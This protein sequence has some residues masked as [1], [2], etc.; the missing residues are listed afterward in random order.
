MSGTKVTA[1]DGQRRAR[2][3]FKIL[4]LPKGEAP[5]EIREQWVGVTVPVAEVLGDRVGFGV[6]T[7]AEVKM[8][9]AIAVSL[10]EA[11]QAL[12]SADKPDAADWW[13]KMPQNQQSQLLF[14]ESWGEL[15]S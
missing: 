11:V 13:E 2:V 8:E 12:R 5:L 3:K 14:E 7:Y 15:I 4:N 1:D 10:P 6:F 9:N